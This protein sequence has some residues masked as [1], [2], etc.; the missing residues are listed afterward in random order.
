MRNR[1]L[2]ASL[3]SA[4]L[5]LFTG[6]A[7]LAQAWTGR[8]RMQGEVD[9]PNGKP[10]EGAKVTLRMGDAGPAPLTTNAKGKW[11]ILGLADG[12]WKVMI[13]KPGYVT[14][15]GQVKIS[16]FQPT[17]PI[18]IRLRVYVQVFGC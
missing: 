8:A 15:E 10:M 12:N 5:L 4:C 16:E 14:S 2:Q 7:L 17:Q 9:D 18:L 3:L 11:S 6:S 13:E 1:G